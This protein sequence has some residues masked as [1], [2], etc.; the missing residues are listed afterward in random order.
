MYF[1]FQARNGYTQHG[2]NNPHNPLAFPLK[3][4]DPTFDKIPA[5]GLVISYTQHW[6]LFNTGIEALFPIDSFTFSAG[7]FIGPSICFATDHHEGGYTYNDIL[8]QGI[9]IKPKLSVFFSFSEHFDIGLAASYHNIFETRGYTQLKENGVNVGTYIDQA[10]G[11]F[12]AFEGSF[13]I[14]YRFYKKIIG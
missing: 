9:A 7:F 11:A 10:G 12:S 4:W 1:D 5:N 2:D 8:Y 13:V 3:P 14:R 6:L